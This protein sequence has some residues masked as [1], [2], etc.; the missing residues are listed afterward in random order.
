MIRVLTFLMLLL[1]AP[2]MAS[3]TIDSFPEGEKYHQTFLAEARSYLQDE[4]KG[5]LATRTLRY[6]DV[7]K[8]EK[9]T[10]LWTAQR[11]E[12]PDGRPSYVL[13]FTQLFP[14]G[15]QELQTAGGFSDL[16]MPYSDELESSLMTVYDQLNR[17]I[18]T[19]EI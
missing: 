16:Y 9:R 7:L 3:G 18:Q 6:R 19:I 13:V 17:H 1:A 4:A 2:L 10:F 14:D 5:P 8:G 15:R 11:F 12:N